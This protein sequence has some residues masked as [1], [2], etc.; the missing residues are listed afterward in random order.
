MLL[1]LGI[2]IDNFV[3]FSEDPAVEDLFYWLLAEQCKIDFMSIINWF[4]GI[5]FS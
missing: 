3:Y 4:L 1:S 5:H 2:Y